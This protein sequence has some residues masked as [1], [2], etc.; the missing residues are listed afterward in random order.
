MVFPSLTLYVFREHVKLIT[1]SSMA[2]TLVFGLVAAVLCASNTITKEINNG[3][4]LLLLTKP[5]HRWT[6]VLSKMGGVFAALTVFVFICNFATLVSLRVS[7]D[8]FRL[9]W[10]P[11]TLFFSTVILCIL[12]GAFRNYHQHKSFPASTS[13]ALMI[14]IPI[15]L[16]ILIFTSSGKV[17]FSKNTEV[18]PALI[19]LLFAVWAMGAITVMLSSKLDMVANLTISALLFFLG[20]V[21]DYFFGNSVG[22]FSI[23][24][25]LY[26]IIP[27]WQ[28]FWLAD[29]LANKQSIPLSYIAWAGVYIVFY[30]SLCSI[31]AVT[32]FSDK[33]I[34][35]NVR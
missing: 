33:E 21:S 25:A 18:I 16:I 6:F 15:L 22:T 26:A 20:L 1:D 12:W 10:I 8:Q 11:Y 28:F 4:A 3:T 24:G 2:T 35:E 31:I 29:A 30:I 32:L 17:D 34:A 27:N 9:S 7:K 19:L 14:G 13:H 23:Q 5:V